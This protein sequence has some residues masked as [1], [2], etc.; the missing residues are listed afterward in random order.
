MSKESKSVSPKQLNELIDKLESLTSL[1]MEFLRGM[2]RG[3][4]GAVGATIVF[5]FLIFLLDRFLSGVGGELPFLENL[6]DFLR[7]NLG[8]PEL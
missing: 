5:A 3:L 6:T 2:V 8:G 1:R 4:G 7:N